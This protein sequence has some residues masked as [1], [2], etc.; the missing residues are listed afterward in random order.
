MSL[1]GVVY[2]EGR[3]GEKLAQA[4]KARKRDALG[5]LRTFAPDLTARQVTI[6]AHGRVRIDHPKYAEVARL[7]ASEPKADGKA[8]GKVLSRPGG[9]PPRQLGGTIDFICP[10]EGTVDIFCGT[11]D[12]DRQGCEVNAICGWS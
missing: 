9:A 8:I 2:V 11:W 12:W 6:D 4:V 3:S 1:D 10:G 7:L 5:M